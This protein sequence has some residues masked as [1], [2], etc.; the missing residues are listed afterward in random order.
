[1]VDALREALRVLVPDGTVV[2]LRP[3]SARYPIEVV[4]SNREFQIGEFAGYGM[5]IVDRAADRAVRRMTDSGWLIVQE[6]KRFEVSKYWDTVEE[7]E[8]FLSE[9]RRIQGVEP[10][11]ADLERAYRK[12]RAGIAGEARIRYRL[13]VMLA[14]YRGGRPTDG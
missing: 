13:P 5:E 1:M 11:Y 14:V 2:D 9:E 7:I 8:P 6:S 3:C 4:T 10:P 12:L